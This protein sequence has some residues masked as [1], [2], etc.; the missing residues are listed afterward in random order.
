MH[1][2]LMGISTLPSDTFL[3]IFHFITQIP[4]VFKISIL[5]PDTL[6]IPSLPPAGRKKFALQPPSKAK[7]SAQAR[8]QNN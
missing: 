8:Q 4:T 2:T 7:L 1:P 5:P 6:G 3:D